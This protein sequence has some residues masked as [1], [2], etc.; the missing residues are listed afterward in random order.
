MKSRYFCRTVHTKEVGNNI[1]IRI[2]I[3]NNQRE[4]ECHTSCDNAKTNTDN[5][6]CGSHLT[7]TNSREEIGVKIRRIYCVKSF[8]L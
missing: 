5:G 8:T 2:R 3:R 7:M 6:V 4:C 1:R